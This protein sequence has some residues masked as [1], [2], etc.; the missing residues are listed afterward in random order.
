M[1]LIR[2]VRLELT[3]IYSDQDF[4]PNISLKQPFQQPIIM[5][6]PKEW[7]NKTKRWNTQTQQTPG[8][9]FKYFFDRFKI[10]LYRHRSPV[11]EYST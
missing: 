4:K 7:H 2:S 9:I 3:L 8:H 11:I 10:N 1:L 6:L 5:I